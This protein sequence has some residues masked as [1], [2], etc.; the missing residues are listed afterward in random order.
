[1]ASDPFSELV[2]QITHIHKYAVYFHK[3]Y[4]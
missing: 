3:V 4:E 1:L 2:R